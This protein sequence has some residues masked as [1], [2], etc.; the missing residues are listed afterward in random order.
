[1]LRAIADNLAQ[2]VEADLYWYCEGDKGLLD[3]VPVTEHTSWSVRKRSLSSLKVVGV[4]IV[5]PV[6]GVM[7][8][9]DLGS[10]LFC[11]P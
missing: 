10:I 6:L 7:R 2:L 9:K 4:V 5:E 1:M 3:R 8:M 11:Y